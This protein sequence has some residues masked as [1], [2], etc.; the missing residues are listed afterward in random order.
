MTDDL[1][2]LPLWYRPVVHAQTITDRATRVASWLSRAVVVLAAWAIVGDFWTHFDQ[3]TKFRRM[4]WELRFEF[5]LDR[6]GSFLV[7]CTFH[8]LEIGL[9]FGLVHWLKTSAGRLNVDV[10]RARE[11]A[12]PDLDPLLD[13]AQRRAVGDTW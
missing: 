3:G 6:V 1:E 9:L 2:R 11:G 5:P 12:V 4:S 8:L 7:V 10:V 13:R